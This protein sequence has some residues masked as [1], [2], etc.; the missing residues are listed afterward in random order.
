MTTVP[1]TILR[2]SCP[3]FAVYFG[4]PNVHTS[5]PIGPNTDTP[6]ST[7][8][9]HPPVP[10]MQHETHHTPHTSRVLGWAPTYEGTNAYFATIRPI[11]FAVYF[12]QPMW[13]TPQ[14]IGPNTHPPLSMPFLPP[15]LPTTTP[16]ATHTIQDTQ[17]T[18][19]ITGTRVDTRRRRY[20]QL[21]R[22]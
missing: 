5:Q 22:D 17:P 8:S 19:H 18:T 4:S 7:R 2:V 16:H 14:H 11:A 1:T 15:T 10:H 12:G 21:C 6:L 20:Q 3:R 9:H 13:N